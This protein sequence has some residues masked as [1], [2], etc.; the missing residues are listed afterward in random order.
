MH[1]N[2]WQLAE[3]APQLKSCSMSI[4]LRQHNYT[5][6]LCEQASVFSPPLKVVVASCLVGVAR[7]K[8]PKEGPFSLGRGHASPKMFEILD[9]WRCIL[10]HFGAQDGI[11]HISPPHQK[12]QQ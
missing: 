4:L 12:K 1:F 11:F 3:P 9:S 6:S 8:G 5:R 10:Q 2:H 7:P